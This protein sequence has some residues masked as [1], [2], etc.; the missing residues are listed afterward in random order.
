MLKVI[1]IF[2]VFLAYFFPITTGRKLP[3]EING[4]LP[5]HTVDARY[6]TQR[7]D[8]S[9]PTEVH[10]GKLA[11]ENTSS[12][13]SVAYYVRNLFR[14]AHRSANTKRPLQELKVRVSVSIFM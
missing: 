6:L 5:H 4:W 9:A 11:Q 12:S 2:I 7:D 14:L 10:E 8:S 1:L 13:T 3:N